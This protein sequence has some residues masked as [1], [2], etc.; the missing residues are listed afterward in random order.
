VAAADAA[1]RTAAAVISTASVVAYIG[2][3]SNLD[4][5]AAQVLRAFDE[6]DA[7][8]DTRLEA[9]SS[10]YGSRPLGPPDQP[11]YV[12]AV[13]RL[14]TGLEPLQL[15]DAL[16]SIERDHRRERGV[17][18]GPR[19]LDL[20][21]LLYGDRRIDHERLS[22]PHP[23]MHRRDFVLRPLV[24][25]SPELDIPGQGALLELLNTCGDLGVH[26]L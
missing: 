7:L 25:I 4:D 5:P 2:I 21:L 8:P 18:W 9:R 3:G 10:L 22:V 16:Q 13:A 24:E 1:N 12:N 19:T 14:T 20:D 26:V 11:D 6:L 17:R 15:L 23:Q